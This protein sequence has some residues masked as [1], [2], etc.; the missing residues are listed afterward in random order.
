MKNNEIEKIG[1]D[2]KL[3]GDSMVWFTVFYF[4]YT[5]IF[6]NKLLFVDN[7]FVFE[8]LLKYFN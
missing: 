8:N 5:Q 6:Y 1:G 7:I 3:W 2:Y 4:V